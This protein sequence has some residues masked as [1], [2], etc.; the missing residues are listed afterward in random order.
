MMQN[1]NNR[2]NCGLWGK[3]QRNGEYTHFQKEHTQ[4]IMIVKNYLKKIFFKDTVNPL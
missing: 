2:G 1:T 3:W 4:F